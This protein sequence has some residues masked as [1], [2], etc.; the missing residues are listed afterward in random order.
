M[1]RGRGRGSAGTGEPCAR[2]WPSAAPVANRSGAIAFRHWPP[3]WPETSIFRRMLYCNFAAGRPICAS[4]AG[5]RVDVCKPHPERSDRPAGHRPQRALPRPLRRQR[6][7][8]DGACLGGRAAA[9]SAHP[10]GRPDVRDRA[11]RRSG[12]AA[13]SSITASCCPPRSASLGLG[14]MAGSLTLEHGAEEHRLRRVRRARPRPR[15]RPQ[16]PRH[17]L[18]V[19]LRRAARRAY[20]FA[21]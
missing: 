16:P 17:H 6:G 21:R 11:R 8:G 1:A 2:L 14:T 12:S 18:T 7:A 3:P 4:P 10:R 20:V 15:P 5:I 13:A 9:R 19:A